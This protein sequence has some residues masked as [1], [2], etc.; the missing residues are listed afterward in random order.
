MSEHYR[1]GDPESGIVWLGV[2]VLLAILFW[3]GF[4]L[5]VLLS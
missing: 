5:G 3:L 2:V 4:G 1:R